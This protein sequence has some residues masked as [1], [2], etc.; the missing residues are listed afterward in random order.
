MT[1]QYML[2]VLM[3]MEGVGETLGLSSF[4]GSLC[5]SGPWVLAGCFSDWVGNS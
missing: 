4:C 1:T 3:E 5:A 2:R